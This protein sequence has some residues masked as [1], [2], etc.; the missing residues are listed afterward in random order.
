VVR[1]GV[2]AYDGKIASLKRLKDD[3]REVAAGLECG[4]G[5]ENFNDIHVGDILEAY[6]QEKVERKL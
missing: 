5:I 3:V 2:V 1:D 4:I 6:T